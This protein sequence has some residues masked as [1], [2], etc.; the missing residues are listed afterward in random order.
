MRKPSRAAIGDRAQHPDRIF[1]EALV[2]IADAADD[3][4]AQVAAGRRCSR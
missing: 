1:L 4:V 3:A 2:R